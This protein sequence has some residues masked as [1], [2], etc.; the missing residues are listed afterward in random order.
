MSFWA[1]GVTQYSNAGLNWT[2]NRQTDA[3]AVPRN[4]S[5]PTFIL[6][7]GYTD[8]ANG[9]PFN[10]TVPAGNSAIGIPAADAAILANYIFGI[11]AV[12]SQ[13]LACSW[14]HC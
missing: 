4:A 10:Y 12:A 11:A 9:I 7:Q 2:H 8:G 1:I 5:M 14:E 3:Q 6:A 13:L